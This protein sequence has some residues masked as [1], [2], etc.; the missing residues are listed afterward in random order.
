[1]RDLYLPPFLACVKAGAATLMSA[2]N[3]LNG[4]PTS[5]NLFTLRKI[6]REEWGFDGMVV[7]DWNSVIEMIP[8]GFAADEKD[9]AARAVTAGVDMEMVSR[10]YVDH[11]ESLIDEGALPLALID[12]AVR[13]ILRVKFRLGLFE[14][15]TNNLDPSDVLLAEDHLRAAR[16]VARESCVLLKNE[17]V[18]PLDRQLGRLAV[19]GPLADS[20][21]DQLGCWVFDGN[22]EDSRTPLAALRQRLGEERVIYHPGLPHARSQDTS[23]FATMTASVSEADAV[24][25]FVGEEAILSGEA[26]S[27]AFLDLPGA[28]EALIDA[29]AETGKPLVAVVMAGRSLVL[30][31][32]LDKVNALLFAWHPG[33]MG[34]PAIADLLLGEASPSGRLPVTFPRTVGQIPLYYNYKNTGRPTPD[35][36][37]SIPTGTPLDPQNFTA[38]YL[39]VD[40]RPLFP[41]GYG[42]TYS[43]FEYSDLR[44]STGRLPLGE[45]LTATVTLTNSG[46]TRA[47]EV[48]QLYVR[49]RVGS[50]T[51]PV[52]ELKGFQRVDLAPGAS[53]EVTF[54]LHTG[55]LAFHNT[56]ME[57]V[58]EPGHFHLWIAPNAAS[59]LRAEFEIVRNA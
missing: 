32:I 5:G 39:D 10:S 8:H 46:S 13:A 6:L 40:H 43:T 2:F 30:S 9:A 11:L 54:A 14:R 52:R 58:T 17:S 1:L 59:G 20:G 55:D 28:Q 42:L 53:Q 21:E 23:A 56:A 16:I 33:T 57:Y 38:G 22:G 27:R 37:P 26:H 18:L 24:V 12:D 45:S 44:L 29:L 36:A 3:D 48:V 7:S 34:G 49:D 41:F 15:P 51:R 50:V 4:V 25:V 19:V 31:P 35:D 47:V